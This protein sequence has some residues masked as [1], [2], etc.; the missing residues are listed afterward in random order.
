[1]ADPEGQVVARVMLSDRALATSAPRGTM[2]GPDR[3]HILD[4]RDPATAPRRRLVSVSA[5][6]AVLADGLSTM[7]CLLPDDRLA[8]GLSRFDGARIEVLI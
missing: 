7:A 4:P 3:G 1:V 2:I 5:P 8:D 6:T